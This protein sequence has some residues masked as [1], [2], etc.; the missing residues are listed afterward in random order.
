MREKCFCIASVNSAGDF[1]PA[2]KLASCSI[3]NIRSR[4][5]SLHRPPIQTDSESNF[6]IQSISF[7]NSVSTL[8]TRYR[9]PW[10]KRATVRV[11]STVFI[12]ASAIPTARLPRTRPITNK[13]APDVVGFLYHLQLYVRITCRLNRTRGLKLSTRVRDK[14]FRPR[15]KIDQGSMGYRIG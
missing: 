8:L 13:T 15:K 9:I 14:Y 6:D 4:L 11:S 10:Y 2:R 3:M 5:V 1:M 12:L 7:L